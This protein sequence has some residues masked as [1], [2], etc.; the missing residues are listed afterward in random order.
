MGWCLVEEASRE[1]VYVTLLKVQRGLE[2][3]QEDVAMA[4]FQEHLFSSS[5]PHH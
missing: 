1:E 5:S 2:A 3:A 4:D